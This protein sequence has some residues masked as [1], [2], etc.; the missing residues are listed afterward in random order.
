MREC[1]DRAKAAVRRLTKIFN[2]QK[3]H[4]VLH[5]QKWLILNRECLTHAPV[6]I[7]VADNLRAVTVSCHARLAHYSTSDAGT[8]SDIPV[9]SGAGT[10]A[11]KIDEIRYK[12]SNHAQTLTTQNKLS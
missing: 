8:T 12:N 10:T 7:V 3:V 1:I 9:A 6:L 11:L 2:V 4:G 5:V